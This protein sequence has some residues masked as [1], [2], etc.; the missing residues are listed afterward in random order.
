MMLLSCFLISLLQ[1][2]FC[3]YHLVLSFFLV[4]YHATFS[5]THYRLFIAIFPSLQKVISEKNLSYYTVYVH[6][7]CAE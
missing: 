2:V 5:R 6:A 7:C 4:H 3:S 1:L